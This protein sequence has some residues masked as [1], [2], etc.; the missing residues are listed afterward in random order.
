MRKKLQTNFSTRQYMLSKDYELY[1]YNDTTINVVERHSHDYYEFYFF[2]EGNVSIEISKKLYPVTSG[3]II[4]IPPSVS[5]RSIIHNVEV[6]YRRF[7]FWISREFCNHLLAL[8]PD[9]GYV[10]QLVE[11]KKTYIFSN[12]RITFNAIQSK[13]LLLL[14]EMHSNHFGKYPQIS[15]YVSGLVL[16]L[17]RLIYEK[18]HPFAPSETQALYPQICDYIESHLEE[19][20]SL[21][22]L[23]NE[24][25]VSKYHIA[26]LFKDNLSLS[27]HQYITKKRLSYCRQSLTSGMNI[28][29]VYQSFGFGDY[30]SFYRAFK[31]EYG[32]SPKDYVASAQNSQM[33]GQNFDA[34]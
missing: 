3:D 21:D 20:L 18:E 34:T 6:P 32:I 13:L 15:L 29:Q 2:M 12:D 9:Y 26:H 7:V 27:V 17:N 22:R 14:A 33:L 31:K 10:M 4:I 19:D 23:A 24:F 16:D 11:E 5:H 25:F 1:Y 8:S 28:T 30:S